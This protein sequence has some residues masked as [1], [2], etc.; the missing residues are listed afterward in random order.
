MEY[1]FLGFVQDLAEN[2]KRRYNKLKKDGEPVIIEIMPPSQYRGGDMK[3]SYVATW[4]G[5]RVCGHS[6]LTGPELQ[7]EIERESSRLGRKGI[8]TI[9]RGPSRR[10]FS[11]RYQFG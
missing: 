10:I 2:Q 1:Q 3:S 8:H 5:I 9:V 4:D 11:S 7:S 6:E